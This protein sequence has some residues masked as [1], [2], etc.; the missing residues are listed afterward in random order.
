MPRLPPPLTLEE[1]GTPG[2]NALEFSATSSVSGGTLMPITVHC[3][4]CGAS[5]TL[6]DSLIGKRVRCKTCA[7]VIPVGEPT[8]RPP[9][10]RVPE[11]ARRRRPLAE[12]EYEERRFRGRRTR[13]SQA[14]MIALVAGGVVA[15]AVLLAI[16]VF[17]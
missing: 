7:S 5:F 8:E 17:G 4:D 13:E 3:S 1:S 9:A 15:G 16:G 6:A 2:Y 11:R 14:G 12:D 10:P